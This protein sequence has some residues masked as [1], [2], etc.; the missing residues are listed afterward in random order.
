M[1]TASL[2]KFSK[3]NPRKLL[4]WAILLLGAGYG[5]QQMA[6]LME[7]QE[8]VRYAFYAGMAAAAA[9]A[10]GAIPALFSRRLSARLHAAM[11]G[12]GGGVMLAASIFSLIVPALALFESSTQSWQGPL[13]VAAAILMGALLMLALE[14]SVPHEHFIKGAEGHQALA[15]KRSWL[16]VI[17]II[18]HNI[19]EGLAIGV[20]YASGDAV[21]ASALAT[22]IS[23]QNV[24]E[25]FVVAMALLAV[26]YSRLV[27]LSV[28]MLS[29]LVEPIMAVTGAIVMTNPMLLPWGLAM[30]AGAMLFV[31]SHEMI[32]ESH[33]Q[34]HEMAAT[35]GLMLGFVL[36][37]VLDT[38][39]G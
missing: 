21:G 22:G 1:N 2:A 12:F 27:A 19:P 3:L 30:A 36:M 31:I 23:L 11:L 8:H 5:L 29:G 34:G 15:L 13:Q 7:Q 32:P 26:G 9:T 18:L 17:A 20:A 14:R 4:G 38:A 37:L 33:R 24:P 39:L 25:G 35:N 6:V 28:G 10:L 16:F